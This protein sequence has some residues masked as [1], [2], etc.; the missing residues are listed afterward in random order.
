MFFPFASFVAEENEDFD[1]EEKEGMSS[2]IP[3]PSQHANTQTPQH[4]PLIERPTPHLLTPKRISNPPS[5]RHSALSSFDRHSSLRSGGRLAEDYKSLMFKHT[6]LEQV[7][8]NI[9]DL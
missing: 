2:Q 4:L 9:K 5:T 6:D 8:S 1:Q 3:T 7:Y